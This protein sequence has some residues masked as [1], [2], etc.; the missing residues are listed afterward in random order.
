MQVFD[1]G[2]E[3]VSPKCCCPLKNNNPSG[4]VL[5]FPAV[6]LV[7]HQTSWEVEERFLLLDLPL[8]PEDLQRIKIG[9]F[10]CKVTIFIIKPISE[11][12]NP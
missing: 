12:K 2:D 1:H 10:W 4:V 5:F 7:L 8:F 9:D 6:L 11:G 3:P